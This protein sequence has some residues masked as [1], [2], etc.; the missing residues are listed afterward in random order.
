MGFNNP[1]CSSK[2]TFLAINHFWLIAVVSRAG[3]AKAN[4]HFYCIGRVTISIILS[5]ACSPLPYLCWFSSGVW[6][7]LHM[8][9]FSLRAAQRRKASHK[10][11][12]SKVW[13][14]LQGNGTFSGP[15]GFS[16]IF[17]ILANSPWIRWLIW[18]SCK[19][20]WSGW[21]LGK[22]SKTEIT[23]SRENDPGNGWW[24]QFMRGY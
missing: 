15:W 22:E 12:C 6:G 14:E 23:Y 17:S 20:G 3:H 2:Q 18:G 21:S 24:S 5:Q 13:H 11:S 7:T 4:R 8:Q 16:H 10:H 1:F 9:M 19:I